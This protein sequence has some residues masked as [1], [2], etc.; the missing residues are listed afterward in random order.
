L[1]AA[2]RCSAR[3]EEWKP[4]GCNL[5]PSKPVPEHAPGLRLQGAPGVRD[6]FP[7]SV[8]MESKTQKPHRLFG[9]GVREIYIGN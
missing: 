2:A 3:G 1:E 8:F 5:P 4:A 7:I 6:H 9:S